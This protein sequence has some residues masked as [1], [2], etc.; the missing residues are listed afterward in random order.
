[1]EIP[2]V[3]KRFGFIVT[4]TIP[5]YDKR[6]LEEGVLKEKQTTLCNVIMA[7]NYLILTKNK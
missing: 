5:F 4:F 2:S 3:L 7:C 6:R 1:M